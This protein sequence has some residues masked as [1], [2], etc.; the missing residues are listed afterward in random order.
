MKLTKEQTSTILSKLNDYRDSRKPCSICGSKHWTVNDCVFEMR[1][2]FGGSYKMGT[3]TAIMPVITLTCDKCGQTIFL[4]AIR[5]GVV[6]II[7]EDPSKAE[8]NGK[9]K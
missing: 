4:N 9:E 1:E 5:L 3:P 2:F 8:S 7:N 6:N